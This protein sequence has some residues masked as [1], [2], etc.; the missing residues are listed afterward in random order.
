MTCTSDY[1]QLVLFD[2]DNGRHILF[3]DFATLVMLIPS[4]C[5]YHVFWNDC[6]VSKFYNLSLLLKEFPQ[7]HLHPSYS[8]D[9]PNTKHSTLSN[10]LLDHVDE[11]SFILLVHGRDRCYEEVFQ[12][13]T[14]EYG[15][16][17]LALLEIEIPFDRYI[18]Q[19]IARLNTEQVNY[20]ATNCLEEYP[21]TSDLIHY[22]TTQAYHSEWT[23][24]KRLTKQKQTSLDIR[25]NDVDHGK[26]VTLSTEDRVQDDLEETNT[27]RKRIFQRRPIHISKSKGISSEHLHYCAQCQN[28]FESIVKYPQHPIIS[29][30]TS[31][32]HASIE[33]SNRFLEHKRILKF[34][35][36]VK[37]N[38]TT[39]IIGKKYYCPFCPRKFSSARNW[40]RH[41]DGMHANFSSFSRNKVSNYLQMLSAMAEDQTETTEKPIG[42]SKRVACWECSRK[43]NAENRLNHYIDEHGTALQFKVTE[44]SNLYSGRNTTVRNLIRNE[45]LILN[46]RIN[47]FKCWECNALLQCGVGL[48]IH[49]M[50]MHTN[51]RIKQTNDP[52]RELRY[53]LAIAQE[54]LAVVQEKVIPKT[55]SHNHAQKSSKSRRL[56]ASSE[57]RR[58]R[59][60]T[61]SNQ[62]ILS[63]NSRQIAK[64]ST[65]GEISSPH[66][67]LS[68]TFHEIQSGPNIYFNIKHVKSNL[69]KRMKPFKLASSR[70]VVMANAPKLT[71]R[72]SSP[73]SV[74]WFPC[75]K[76]SRK[77]IA[78]T[79][80]VNHFINKHGLSLRSKIIELSCQNSNRTTGV[81]C[82]VNS[83]KPSFG[84][85]KCTKKFTSHGGVLSHFILKHLNSI[86]C[87]D[88]DPSSLPENR[89]AM[90]P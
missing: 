80:R 65:S 69:S 62:R 25:Y 68:T 73:R 66:C 29:H 83:A 34:N 54:R 41:I 48:L 85:W 77:F 42:L 20:N 33:K 55:K 24:V 72:Q 39:S 32:P 11:F 44:I 56:D 82:T 17:K 87:S 60:R 2:C 22:D 84:C 8:K 90:V 47:V 70:P 58:I 6:K 86:L 74:K 52:S 15:R 36:K 64:Q 9:T 79:D 18:G 13:V 35:Q 16:D 89:L 51:F 10:Y 3:T 78:T 50:K 1:R 81:P 61:S 88:E 37:H 31:T 75:W 57:H 63:E 14:Q 28:R 4:T 27:A 38:V 23:T 5:E 30:S 43:C 21:S 40:D 12:C 46:T 67:F 76:C 59:H 45:R 53:Q 49:F 19:I 71:N 7:I 26:I